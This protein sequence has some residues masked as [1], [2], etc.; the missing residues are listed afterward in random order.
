MILV[1]WFAAAPFIVVA[2]VFVVSVF[3]FRKSVQWRFTPR[4]LTRVAS[5]PAS[6]LSGFSLLFLIIVVT[7]C[8][9]SYPAE[10][11]PSRNA[12]L[13]VTNSDWGGV[14]ENSSISLWQKRGFRQQLIYWDS[15]MGVSPEDVTW[16]S[17]SEILVRTNDS[18]GRCTNAPGIT[19][20]C[21]LATVTTSASR[22]DPSR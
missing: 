17:D 12:A 5:L 3:A 14:G 15:F 10:Y 18:T 7:V 6:V 8:D 1:D 22:P 13:R 21:Q 2:T 4:L 19:V 16:L 9:T 11:S 20:R